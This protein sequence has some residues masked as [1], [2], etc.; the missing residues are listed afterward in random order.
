SPDTRPSTAMVSPTSK[1]TAIETRLTVLDILRQSPDTLTF[2]FDNSN[3]AFP[4]HQP[5][6]FLR[7]AIPMEQGEQWRSFTISSSPTQN[8]TVD[9]TV[10]S[11]PTGFATLALHNNVTKGSELAVKGPYGNYH[12]DPDSHREPLVLISAGSGIT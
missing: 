6:Q 5:G 7:V 8:T 12:F 10:K 2:R 1:S 11:G 9:I 3:G 4:R